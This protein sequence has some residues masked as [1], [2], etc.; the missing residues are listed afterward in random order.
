[1]TLGPTCFFLIWVGILRVGV[2][3]DLP[4][5]SEQAC[6]QYVF[7][8]VAVLLCDYLLVI[9]GKRYSVTV[10]TRKPECIIYSTS[11]SMFIELVFVLTH[12]LQP[13]R[14]QLILCLLFIFLCGL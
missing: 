14:Y 8:D 11:F 4:W 6:L 7:S 13:G 12:S 9:P 5:L 10:K 3:F 1:M 2:E